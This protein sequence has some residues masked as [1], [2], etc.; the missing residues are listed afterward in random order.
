MRRIALLSAIFIVSSLPSWGSNPNAQSSVESTREAQRHSQPT[1]SDNN[2]RPRQSPHVE[3]SSFALPRAASQ[4]LTNIQALITKGDALQ[5]ADKYEQAIETYRE[6]IR[7]DPNSSGLHEKLASALLAKHN[8]SAAQQENLAA[9]KLNPKSARAHQ[10]LGLVMGMTGEYP[11]TIAQ[12]NAAIAIQPN[13]QEAYAVL[14]KALSESGHYDEAVAALQKAISLDESDFDSI[15][16]LGA[17]LGRKKDFPHAISVY[18]KA[19]ALNPKSW[20]AHMG[21]GQA[22]GHSGDTE[23]QIIE[24]KKA[25][26]LAP[27]DATAHGRLGAALYGTGDVQGALEEGSAANKIRMASQGPNAIG[28]FIFGWACVFILFGLIFAVIFVGSEFEPQ[29]G[30]ELVNSFLF[31]FY[32]EKPGRFVITSRRLLF[33]PEAFSRWFGA[34]RVSIERD[35]I[36]K[37]DASRTAAGGALVIETA[38]GSTLQFKMPKLVYDPLMKGLQ[39][40]GYSGH[41]S[42]PDSDTL[43]LNI[44]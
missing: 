4:Q 34:T 17:V 13:Y 22:Y 5:E 29:E 41:F 35:L 20:V 40:V 43:R 21:L 24:L 2:Q 23:N 19:I 1:K 39:S 25:V 7:I 30:E 11:A 32:K 8:L 3:S 31:V 16:T 14:G 28:H 36:S 33:V 9:L 37:I 27:S 42:N 15:L 26:A 6:A 38:D 18:K 12:E 44:L 10:Q